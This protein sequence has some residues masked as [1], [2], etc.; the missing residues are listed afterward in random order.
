[1]ARA[2]RV[3]L[4]KGWAWMVVLGTFGNL[5]LVVGILKSFGVLLVELS[6]IYNVPA[7][8]LAS[9]QSLCG[10]LHLGLA[11]LSNNLSQR[12]SH[13]LVV[14][15]G[16]VLSVVGLV[17][18]SFVRD[19]GWFFITYGVITGL[20]F[21]LILAPALVMPG[22]YFEKK[23]PLALGLSSSG[24][25]LG[26]FIF[27][28]LMRF[29]LDEYSVGGCLLIMGGIMLHVCPFALLYRPTL[30]WEKKSYTTNKTKHI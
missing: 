16:G 3:P 21:G 12:F 1:M 24:S 4:D 29:L 20:G 30:Y 23:L 14:F 15:C 13:R 8:L 25:G 17:A 22:L 2:T 7:S 5:A 26:S 27:P 28:N 11:P 10:W 6:H 19:V 9:S 18:T